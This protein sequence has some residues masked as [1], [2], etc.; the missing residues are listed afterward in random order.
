MSEFH[1][2]S[3]DPGLEPEPSPRQGSPSHRPLHRSLNGQVAHV[4]SPRKP[5]LTPRLQHLP[6]LHSQDTMCFSPVTCYCHCLFCVYDP[7]LDSES[8]RARTVCLYLSC[9]GGGRGVGGGPGDQQRCSKEPS[10]LQSSSSPNGCEEQD[11]GAQWPWSLVNPGAG[12][13]LHG[14]GDTPR[15]PGSMT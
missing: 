6:P 9:G 7:E 11:F 3:P 2:L 5:S 13:Q 15:S 10:S 14:H 12:W 8:L 1:P 4:S